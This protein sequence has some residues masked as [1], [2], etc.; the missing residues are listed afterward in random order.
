LPTLRPGQLLSDRYEVKGTVAFGGLGWIYLALDRVLGR[1]VILKGLLN[2]HDRRLIE[3]A[4]QEREY[5]AAV[6][7]PAIVSI[8]DFLPH[9]GQG[10]I[11]M[12]CVNGRSLS[13]IRKDAGGP[14]P[15]GDALAYIHDALE[16]LQHLH[17]QGLVYCD[18]KPDNVMIEED[19]LKLI[20]L[21]AVRRVDEVG[22]DVYGSRGYSAPEASERPSPSSDL[23]SVGR[24]LAV[25]VASFDFQG[26][27]EHQ[28]PTPASCEV[29]LRH[30]ALHALLSR[31]THREPAQRF[32]SA[33]E[34]RE[35]IAGVLLLEDPRPGAPLPPGQ[36]FSLE[37][38]AHG[39]DP[40]RSPCLPLLQGDPQEEGVELEQAAD[41]LPPGDRRRELLLRGVRGYP[42]SAGLRLRLAGELAHA[43]A[44]QE[45][46]QHLEPLAAGS[47]QRAW[48]RGLL[49]L[50]RGRADEA[51]EA[52]R[53]VLQQ[54]PG[55]LGGWLALACALE[56]RGQIAEALALHERVQRAMPSTLGALG[57]FRCL[58]AQGQR[59]EAAAALKGVSLSSAHRER[60]C[61][62]RASLLLSQAP[63]LD[64]VL[65]AAEALEESAAGE[66]ML[67]R[68]LLVAETLQAARQRAAS[69]EV[70]GGTVLGV[71]IQERA[72]RE[73]AAQA[74]QRCARLTDDLALRS[75]LLDQASKHRPWSLF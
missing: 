26:E 46:Q 25:L 71:P 63:D 39:E 61:L 73:A 17:E 56:S 40:Y 69:G 57:R 29:F 33:A 9:E 50:K 36:R 62:E 1:W 68:A 58:L 41:R 4:T 45:A 35:Q 13:R 51:V 48:G 66:Q 2:T 74:F 6:K 28:L 11:V 8:H 15:V 60:S 30:P 3:V 27:F 37:P 59:R 42:R 34:F 16:A 43:G 7:H 12:E 20:D 64:D 49:A 23:Y 10:F 47:W 38:P 21:G 53:E 22:G 52:F 72:L 54:R 75:Y 55:E 31:S 14:L 18:F 65:E 44:W 32:A 67:A 24:T 19:T 5:L 70:R